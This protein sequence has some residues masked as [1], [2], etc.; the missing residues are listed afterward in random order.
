MKLKVGDK[1]KHKA[2]DEKMVIVDL[3]P[4]EDYPIICRR[5]KVEKKRY[6]TE[7]FKEEEL[8]LIEE[9]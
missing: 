7:R 2:T 6:G 3:D 1:V 5:Y 9:K 8:E 4:E